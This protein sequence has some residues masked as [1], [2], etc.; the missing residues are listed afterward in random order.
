MRVHGGSPW[1]CAVQRPTDD[2]EFPRDAA[3]LSALETSTTLDDNVC[4]VLKAKLLVQNSVKHQFFCVPKK[5]WSFFH[6]L[7]GLIFA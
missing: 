4:L 3:H 7:F 6:C 5:F 2:A 1:S